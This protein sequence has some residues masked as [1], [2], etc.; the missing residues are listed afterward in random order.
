[1]VKIPIEPYWKQVQETFMR[2]R[3]QWVMESE[4][5]AADMA[6]WLAREYGAILR[7]RKHLYF[8]FNTEKEADYFVL[9][10]GERNG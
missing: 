9:V 1:M 6:L 8:V 2:R 3:D 10:F 4:Q 7:G 5:L